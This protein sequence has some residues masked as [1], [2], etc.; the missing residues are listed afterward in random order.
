M[1]SELLT[2]NYKPPNGW[3]YLVIIMQNSLDQLGWIELSINLD[4]NT[5]TFFA[6]I[7]SFTLR[8]L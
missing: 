3:K 5:V 2:Y 4:G 6:K 1:A 8:L 7:H